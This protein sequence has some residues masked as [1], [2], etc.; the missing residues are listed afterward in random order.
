MAN[1]LGIDLRRPERMQE[2]MIAGRAVIMAPV[3]RL[4]EVK[5]GAF[6][7]NDLEALVLEFPPKLRI[8]GLLGVNSLERFRPT[9]E[10][11]TASVV[12]RSRKLNEF[13]EP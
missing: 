12:L 1:L 4:R 9:F 5:V 2:V 11:E 3:I 13:L 7:V 10:F 6:P 8:D